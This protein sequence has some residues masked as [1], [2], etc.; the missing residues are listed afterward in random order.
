MNDF[1]MKMIEEIQRRNDALN[2]S[3]LLPM[4]EL[5]RLH[6][7]ALEPAWATAHKSMLDTFKQSI[8]LEL[9]SEKTR[10]LSALGLLPKDFPTIK[11]VMGETSRLALEAASVGMIGRFRIPELAELSRIPKILEDLGMKTRFSSIEQSLKGFH[12]P[13][14]DSLDP[15]GSFERIAKLS[16]LGASVRALSFEP[17]VLSSIE[18]AIG[19]WRDIPA[20]LLTDSLGRENYFIRKGFDTSLIALPEPAFT[21][22][23]E[24]STVLDAE[25]LIPDADGEAFEIEAVDLTEEEQHLFLRSTRAFRLLS[26]FERKLRDYVHCVMMKHYGSG[27]ERKR[28]PENGKACERWEQKRETA[29]KNGEDLLDLI[30]YAD[31]TDYA[32]LILR[33]DNWKEH[34]CAV[35]RDEEELRVAF[36]RIEK[37]RIV[38]MHCR[39]ITKS[40]LVVLC[41]ETTLILSAVGIFKKN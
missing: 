29:S 36:R 10:S 19:R 37:I 28:A 14:I 13:W 15:S 31:F 4:K 23:L 11:S 30:H 16:T 34:F 6:Q 18:R 26:V 17:R 25:L 20:A 38:T 3:L 41:I 7:L 5:G 24:V 33:K 35:F 27:W 39:A 40:D 12:S 9:V 32:K 1:K 22:S 21:E 2:K 8:A